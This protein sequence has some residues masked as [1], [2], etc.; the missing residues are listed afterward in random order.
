ML[1]VTK[2]YFT[3]QKGWH[4]V[5]SMYELNYVINCL[6]FIKLYFDKFTGISH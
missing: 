6:I 2:D 3:Y 4:F 1:W 5:S